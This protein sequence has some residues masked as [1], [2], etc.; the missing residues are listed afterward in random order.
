MII[1]VT[2]RFAQQ[3]EKDFSLYHFGIDDLVVKLQETPMISLKYPIVKAK[4]YIK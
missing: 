4:F 2:H 1:K 3:F